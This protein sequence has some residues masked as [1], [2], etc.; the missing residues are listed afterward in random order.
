MRATRGMREKLWFMGTQPSRNSRRIEQISPSSLEHAESAGPQDRVDSAS[1]SC[2][3]NVPER[4][5]GIESHSLSDTLQRR[6]DLLLSGCN[7]CKPPCLVNLHAN[8]FDTTHRGWNREGRG[9]RGRLMGTFLLPP[10]SSARDM[11][12]LWVAVLV[13][14]G[15]GEAAALCAFHASSCSARL[16]CASLWLAAVCLGLSTSSRGFW[17]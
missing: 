16:C 15:P 1:R 17:I 13:K 8:S 14:L 4:G 12:T 5:E 2:K 7:S 10:A 6:V 3:A 9:G 11:S